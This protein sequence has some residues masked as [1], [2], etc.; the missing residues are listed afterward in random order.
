MSNIFHHFQHYS[1]PSSIYN[2]LLVE[3]LYYSLH[4]YFLSYNLELPELTSIANHI[5]QS[6]H[7]ILY[8]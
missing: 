6:K 5:E 2:Q 3:R 8:L 4:I 1:Y 7:T